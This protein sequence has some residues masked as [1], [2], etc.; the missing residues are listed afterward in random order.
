[1]SDHRAS[2]C[3]CG[4]FASRRRVLAGIG[5]AGAA[6]LVGCEGGEPPI[7]FVDEETVRQMGLETWEQMR[8]DVPLSA[9]A[10]YRRRLRRVGAQLV[11]AAGGNPEAWEFRVFQGSD[12]NA[13]A[14]PGMKVGVFEG[15]MQLVAND[16]QLAAVVAHEIAHLREDH[17]RA[18]TNTRIL[19]ELGLELSRTALEVGEIGF[20]PEIAAVLGL[21]TQ[22]G[23]TL[24]YSRA[25]EREADRLGVRLMHQADF[26]PHAAV[27]L[28]ERMAERGP[29]QISFLSTHPA[30]ADRAET[31]RHFIAQTYG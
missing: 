7:E 10:S 24:P 15:M 4:V 6:A 27:R 17:A 9:N 26:D 31:L 25:Q 8:K 29:S 3:L 21:G 22:V 5:A 23:I 1:M 12:I 14:V 30:A 2:S 20:A 28:W 11:A 16:A 18:R 13:F 19:R